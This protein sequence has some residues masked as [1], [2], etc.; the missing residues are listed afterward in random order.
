LVEDAAYTFQENDHGFA[1]NE[2]GNFGSDHIKLLRILSAQ[3]PRVAAHVG[4]ANELINDCL[5]AAERAVAR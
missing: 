5:W 4:G 1:F 2:S 3:P